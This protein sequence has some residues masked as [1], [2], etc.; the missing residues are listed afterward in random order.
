MNIR[1]DLLCLTELALKL[2]V[3]HT[4]EN[5]NNAHIRKCGFQQPML[6]SR[7]S[8]SDSFFLEKFCE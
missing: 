3:N 5:Q 6:N 7:S 8:S 4:A 2:L 1:I